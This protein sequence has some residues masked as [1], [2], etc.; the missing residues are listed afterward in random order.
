MRRGGLRFRTR[1]VRTREEFVRAIESETFD[2]VLSDFTLPAFDGLSAVRLLREKH[3]NVPFILVTSPR[4]EEVAMECLREG[5]TDFIEKPDVN[6]AV[7]KQVRKL[8]RDYPAVA[9]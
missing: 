6:V 4:S 9:G 2:L 5:A 8:L 3:P 1:Q 7:M